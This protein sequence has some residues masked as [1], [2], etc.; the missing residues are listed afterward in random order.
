MEGGAIA[1]YNLGAGLRERGHSLRILSMNTWKQHCDLTKVPAEFRSATQYELVEVDIRIKAWDAFLNLFGK[2]S[3]H[4]S[5]FD[6]GGFHQQLTKLLK[7][8]EFD[9]I[10][11]ESLFTTPYIE[12]VRGLSQAQL[13][14]RSHNVEHQIWQNLAQNETNPLKKAYLNLLWKRL[15]RYECEAL[16]KLDGVASI[17]KADIEVFRKLGIQTPMKYV[18]FG[19]DFSSSDYGEY[20]PPQAQDLSLFHVGSMEW[21][22][23]QEAFA[24]FLDKVWPKVHAQHPEIKLHL[25]GKN[26]PF[27]ISESRYPNLVVTSGYVDGKAY[28]KGKP[29]MVVPSF[30]GSGVRVKIIEGLALGKVIVTTENGALGINYRQGENLFVSDTMTGFAE[31][32]SSCISNPGLLHNVSSAARQFA[33]QEY[34]HVETARK[35]EEAVG[36]A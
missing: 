15:K 5:R 25:A 21:R 29:I 20:L 22:P 7:V 4:I 27:W 17:T 31:A 12:T 32:I 23:H 6:D 36:I 28:M 35:L 19:I 13:W 3:Y 33:Q 24:W 1:M 16:R 26:M 34:G 14:M 18:P 2:E 30:S 8:E 10:L 11:L 9:L